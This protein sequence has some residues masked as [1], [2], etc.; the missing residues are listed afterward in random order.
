MRTQQRA[1]P[2]TAEARKRI[3][4]IYGILCARPSDI[5]EHL[6]ILRRY[7][8]GADGVI[9][10]GVR[11]ITST[12][13]FLAARPRWLLSV[14]IQHPRQVG[15]DLDL[16][17]TLAAE[18]GLDFRFWLADDRTIDLPEADVLFIDTLHT[19]DQLRAEL[20]R[21]ACR[22]RKWILLHDTE[23]FAE[24]GEAKRARGLRPALEEFLADP[25]LGA[26]WAVHEVHRNNNGL[27]VLR[28]QWAGGP[29]GLG[30]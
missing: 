5:H 22:A 27:T 21:H 11:G 17:E 13:A 30:I 2:R 29:M 8:A 16:V 9:E 7:A 28:C 26:P 18:A 12:W 25:T 23:T 1:A 14:D 6:P 20:W 15:G 3:E 10:L 4:E 24:K 19:Y